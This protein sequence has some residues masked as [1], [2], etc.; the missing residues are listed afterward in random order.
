[1]YTLSNRI[2]HNQGRNI[3]LTPNIPPRSFAVDLHRP[4]HY[5][6]TDLPSVQYRLVLSAKNS[7]KME[8]HDVDY[9][10]SRFFQSW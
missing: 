3:L 8:S 10:V 9:F 1:M 6:A 2:H 5:A 7:I 4:Q